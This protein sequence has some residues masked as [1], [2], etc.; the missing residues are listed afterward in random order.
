MHTRR[1][2]LRRTVSSDNTDLQAVALSTNGLG[3][4]PEG[5]ELR[6]DIEAVASCLAMICSIWSGVLGLARARSQSSL[7]DRHFPS[8]KARGMAVHGS[9]QIFQS[10]LDIL[11][12]TE[13]TA[14]EAGSELFCD[15]GG[16]AV[17]RRMDCDL[18]V[19]LFKEE[20]FARPKS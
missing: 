5:D 18:L 17:R 3:K 9:N 20:T 4:E 6:A 12:L 19:A 16:N 14:R 13:F 7:G 2:H 1:D 8:Q 10:M 15:M 11:Q